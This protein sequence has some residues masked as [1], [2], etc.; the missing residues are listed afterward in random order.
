MTPRAARQ[1]R[2]CARLL[3]IIGTLG[4]FVTFGLSFFLIAYYSA[5]RPHDP[6]PERGWTVGLSW[7]HP[8]SYGTA[9]DEGR[10]QWLSFWFI[11]SFGLIALGEATKAYKLNDY[12][13]YRK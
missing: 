6:Q 8:T 10:L 2:I 12:S 4:C 5:K 9:E 13:G 1:W 3:K 11:P 7:T